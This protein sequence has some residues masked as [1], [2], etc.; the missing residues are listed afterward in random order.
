AQYASDRHGNDISIN[1]L[2]AYDF[3]ARS[4]LY[5]G[6]NR[7]RKDPFAVTDLGNQVFVKLSYLFAF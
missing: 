3:T 7:Q 2:F 4:A 1:S 5:I 6:Y